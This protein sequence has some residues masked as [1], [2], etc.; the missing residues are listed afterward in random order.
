MHKTQPVFALS[1]D[2]VLY[3]VI[4]EEARLKPGLIP[5]HK[6]PVRTLSELRDVAKIVFKTDP[7]L[8]C[9][10]TKIYDNQYL[11]CLF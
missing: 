7:Q 4:V 6:G 3:P 1:L 5:T 10:K 9:V 2:G 11:Y 8:H